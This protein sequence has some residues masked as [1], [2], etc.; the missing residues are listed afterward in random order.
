MYSLTEGYRLIGANEKAKSAYQ[1]YLKLEPNDE[2]VRE[3]LNSLS[4]K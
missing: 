2:D 1:Q 4:K 3:K